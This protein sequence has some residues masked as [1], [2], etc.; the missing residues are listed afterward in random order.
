MNV[1]K[2]CKHGRILYDDRDIWIGK[3]LAY[4]GEFSEQEVRLFEAVVR[5]G[6]DVFDVG[7]NIG[8][9]TIPLARM[10]GPEGSVVSIEPERMNYY[11]LCAN[12][13]INNLSQ[14]VC[15][16]YGVSDECGTMLVPDLDRNI[17]QNF[18]G[19]ELAEIKD[20][21]DGQM[22]SVIRLDQLG[23]NCRSVKLIKVDVEGMEE[24]VLRGATRTIEKYRPFLYVEND[25]AEKS[26]GLISYIESLGYKTLDHKPPF[27]NPEN[28][29][30]KKIDIFKNVVSRNLFCHPQEIEIPFDPAAFDMS[31]LG[32]R[33]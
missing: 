1:M 9:F 10:V 18:G 28:F 23:F 26:R 31:P 4:Y 14:V 15:W 27:W 19:L 3:S 17:E 20:N 24:R 21:I 13:A 5:P 22:V 8:V 30:N 25:R 6:D 7:A 2:T 29:A 16:H 11:T 12:V 32:D 33:S